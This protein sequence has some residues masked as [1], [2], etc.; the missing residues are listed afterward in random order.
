MVPFLYSS[1]QV[2]FRWEVFCKINFYQIQIEDA[3]CISYLSCF[4]CFCS[5]YF[6]SSLGE[7]KQTPTHLTP[8]TSLSYLLV[9]SPTTSR[10]YLTSYWTKTSDPSLSFP[11]KLDRIIHIIQTRHD[12]SRLIPPD[13][14]WSF[15]IN[16]KA[17]NHEFSYCLNDDSEGTHV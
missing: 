10:P 13:R 12:H 6:F 17:Y 3:N 5:I 7:Q 1:C 11:N 16:P 8:T 9:P 15:M 14:T 4:F 2:T